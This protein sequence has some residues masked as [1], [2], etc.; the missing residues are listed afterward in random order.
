MDSRFD[1]QDGGAEGGPR[2]QGLV[3]SAHKLLTLYDGEQT[4]QPLHYYHDDIDCYARLR[5]SLQEVLGVV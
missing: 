2:F 5:N 3:A 4:I 1:G